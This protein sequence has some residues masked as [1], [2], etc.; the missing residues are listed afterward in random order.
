MDEGLGMGSDSSG[1]GA[2]RLQ[3]TLDSRGDDVANV[4]C[5]VM[6]ASGLGLGG[7]DPAGMGY[8]SNERV[9][10]RLRP[11]T[12]SNSRKSLRPGLSEHGDH[13]LPEHIRVKPDRVA[14]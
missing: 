12:S 9:V 2:K 5:L 8:R 14:P 3:V 7:Y 6:G 10:Y 11:D 4:L 1:D 13:T